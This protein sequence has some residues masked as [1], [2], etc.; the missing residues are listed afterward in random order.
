MHTFDI[1]VRYAKYKWVAQ[2]PEAHKWTVTP[3]ASPRAAVDEL[4]ATLA[5]GKPCRLDPVVAQR[6]YR[7]TVFD[8]TPSTPSTSSIP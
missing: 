6:W 2:C 7:L 5:A 1:N 3:H 4:A 8:S